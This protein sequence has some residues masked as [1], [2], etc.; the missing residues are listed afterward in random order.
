MNK[1][2]IIWLSC[3]QATF[4]ISKK[5]EGKLSMKERIQLRLHLGMCGFCS[6][7]QKQTLF[8]TKNAP[9]IHEQVDIT[10]SEEKKTEIKELMK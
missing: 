6:R 2:N 7:F 3:K 4:L 5:E 1:L 10:L 8:F 9:H